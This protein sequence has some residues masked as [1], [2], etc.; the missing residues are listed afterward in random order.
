VVSHAVMGQPKSSTHDLKTCAQ[1]LLAS[2][3]SS[4]VVGPGVTPAPCGQPAYSIHMTYDDDSLHCAFTTLQFGALYTG[5]GVGVGDG[6]GDGDEDGVGD[7]VGDEEGDV[8]GVGMY[9]G[10][11]E[12]DGDGDGRG[13]GVG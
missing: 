1:L 6:E 7:G 13:V 3:Q 2:K 12:G 4:V 10:E 5:V 9:E 11:G 8:D